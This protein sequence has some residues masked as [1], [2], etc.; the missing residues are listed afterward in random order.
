[1]DELLPPRNRRPLIGL[2][3]GQE[4]SY[5]VIALVEGRVY[6]SGRQNQLGTGYTGAVEEAG[7]L[8]V[9][10][11]IPHRVAFGPRD[12]SAQAAEQAAAA[13]LESIDGLILTGGPDLDPEVFGEEP[14]PGLGKIDLPRDRFE[15]AL[16]RQALDR[17][18]PVLGICRGEQ[19]LA[20]AAGGDLYQDLAAQKPDRLKHRQ[21]A[22]RDVATHHVDLGVGTLAR[23]LLGVPRIKVNSFHH[24]AVRRVPQGWLASALAPDGVI[25]AV[26][27]DPGAGRPGWALGVQWHPENMW[28]SEPTFLRL[29]RGLV[30]AAGRRRDR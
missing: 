15:L 6:D 25:E 1:M 8:P 24:Q 21:E 22:A 29:F 27:P 19:V 4:V 14:I 30:E 28:L 17:G 20:V 18:V 26:E 7:G 12:G 9:A 16:A 5:N 2:T 13:V 10:V 23:E 3:C 11:V